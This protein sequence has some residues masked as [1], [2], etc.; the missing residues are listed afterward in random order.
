MDAYVLARDKFSLAKRMDFD[1][2][3]AEIA[4]PE[5]IANYRAK[6]L[7]CDSVLDIGCGM[8]GDTIA[9]AGTCGK[10]TAIEM[11]SQRA[12]FASKNCEAYNRKNVK[13]IQENAM[14]SDLARFGARYAFSDPSRRVEGRRVKGFSETIPP[15]DQLIQKLAGFK[16][17]CIEA[18]QQ[19]KPEEII[20]DC[21]KEYI[22]L[23]GELVCLSLYFGE[24]KKCDRSAVILP[25]GSRLESR[26][27]AKKPK[28]EKLKKYFFEVDP[29]VERAGLIP[30]LAKDLGNLA[31]SRDFL[32]SKEEIKSPFFKN[33]FQFLAET[34]MKELPEKLRKLDAKKVVLRG[35][36]DPEEQLS[37]KHNLESGLVGTRKLHVFMGKKVMIARN[38]GIQK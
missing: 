21:E 1:R 33:S 25:A 30:E 3:S 6:R 22:S 37:L 5:I 2:E 32:T 23:N 13:I 20:F 11:D 27:K 28:K 9:L 7:A 18:S 24:L 8:G 35:R 4:T 26:A 16:G 36:M 10:V 19:L 29:A 15:T 38:L 12:E 31:S 17:F 34:T 14:E